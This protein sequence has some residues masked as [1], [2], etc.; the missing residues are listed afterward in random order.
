MKTPPTRTKKKNKHIVYKTKGRKVKFR[1]FFYCLKNSNACNLKKSN[2]ACKKNDSWA[3]QQRKSTQKV[4]TVAKSLHVFAQ[5]PLKHCVNNSFL[6]AFLRL[7]Q[8]SLLRFGARFVY[9]DTK[10]QPTCKNATNQAFVVN[11][12]HQ[13]PLLCVSLK[14]YAKNKTRPY[15]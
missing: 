4:C 10:K 11:L 3:K 1:P 7:K 12:T 9:P 2:V 15:P 6:S 8:K 14:Y 13:T 5:M